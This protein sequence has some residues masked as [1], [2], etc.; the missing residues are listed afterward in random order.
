MK[1]QHIV[2]ISPSNGAATWGAIYKITPPALLALSAKATQQSLTLSTVPAQLFQ[3]N[4]VIG[5]FGNETEAQLLAGGVVSA[6]VLV[7]QAPEQAQA[8]DENAEAEAKTAEKEGPL[9]SDSK[10]VFR[11][12]RAIVE[13]CP[14]GLCAAYVEQTLRRWVPRPK[15]PDGIYW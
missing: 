7:A 5:W 1:I 14:E 12:N 15:T 4:K 9:D 3:R 11:I 2:K 6:Y 13:L 10:A 8:Q